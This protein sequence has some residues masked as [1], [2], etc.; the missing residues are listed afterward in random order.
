MH[1]LILGGHLTEQE[2]QYCIFNFHYTYLAKSPTWPEYCIL[3]PS[4]TQP[5]SS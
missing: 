3:R 4:C 2:T 5:S 1:F